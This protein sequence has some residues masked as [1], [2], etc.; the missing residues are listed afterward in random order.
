[1]LGAEIR[2]AQ[3][4]GLRFH[5]TRGSMDLGRSAGGLPPDQV[6]SD[7]DEILA[8]SADAVARW[9]DPSPGSMLRIAL[10]PARRSR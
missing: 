5:P 2:A 8:A 7:R 10:A 4:V 9:H 3:Q 1:M 6:V